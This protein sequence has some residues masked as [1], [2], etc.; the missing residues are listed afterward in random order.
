M[1]S[2]KNN[3]ENYMDIPSTFMQQWVN[4]K[5]SMAMCS[6]QGVAIAR[7]DRVISD[8]VV[9]ILSFLRDVK[10]ATIEQI[11][12][13]TKI[14]FSVIEKSLLSQ[15]FVNMFILTDLQDSY[16]FKSENVLKIYT[17]DFSGVY[18]LSIEGYDMTNW[19]WTDY[20]VSSTVVKKALIQTDIYVELSKSTTVS[21][22]NYEQF[23]E[24]RIGQ[25]SN[26]VDF[27]VSLEYNLN[28]EYIW[29]Y[30]GFIVEAGDE[31]LYL[32][33][34]LSNLESIFHETKIGLKYFPNGE[35]TFPKLLLIIETANSRNLN[36]IKNTIG[37]V[38]SWSGENVAIVALDS[39]KEKGL[40]N[41]NVYT[42][43][44]SVDDNGNKDIKVGNINMAIFK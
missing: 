8:D 14:D 7:Q 31:D 21:I 42:I 11:S 44:T 5:F 32:R 40:A 12:A 39:I 28:N 41:S 38:T 37:N 16:E 17:L 9:K 26:D 20:L 10:F 29:N 35:N 30:A 34:K 43:V 33:D 1:A 6:R 27:F 19:R 24:F 23:K 22:R 36:A 18:L 3:I 4:P 13:G 25:N 15:H 2:I